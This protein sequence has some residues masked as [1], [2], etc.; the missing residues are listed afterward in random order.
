MSP[1]RKVIFPSWGADVT[2]KSA[3]IAENSRRMG[4]LMTV[5]EVAEYLRT[6]PTAL[7]TMRHRGEGP[8]A[9]K[10]GRKLLYARSDLDA[11]LGRLYMEQAGAA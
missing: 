6:T 4:P 7:Y 2:L 9:V 3:R 1:Y 10:V 11:Y 8:P 5:D